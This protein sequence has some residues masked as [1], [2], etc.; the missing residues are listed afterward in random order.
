MITYKTRGTCSVAIEL[1]IDGNNKITHC[2]FIQ[3]CKGNTTGLARMVIGRDADE[4]R[5][6][7]RGIPCRGDTSCPDQ[8]S[9]AIDEWKRKN[10]G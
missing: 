9:N 1:D 7:L 5:D 6:T 3:G 2:K 8:L 4:V 10:A